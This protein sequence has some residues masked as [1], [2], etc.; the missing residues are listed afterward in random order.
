MKKDINDKIAQVTPLLTEIVKLSNTR[1]NIVQECP[2]SPIVMLTIKEYTE[3]VK[4]IS[5]HT[6]RQLVMQALPLFCN[7]D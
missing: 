2:A 6:I 5:E 4:G 3:A 1:G 7:K